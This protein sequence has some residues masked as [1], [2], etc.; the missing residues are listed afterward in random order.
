MKIEHL[1]QAAGIVSKLGGR[2]PASAVTEV[3]L[4]KG[5]TMPMVL[6]P[7]TAVTFTK[8]IESGGAPWALRAISCFTLAARGYIR[9]QIQLPNGRFLFGRNGIDV[10][11]FCG[12]GSSRWA[13]DP[14]LICEPGSKIQVK[15]SDDLHLLTETASVMMTFEGACLYYVR[16]GKPVKDGAD[17]A[18][19]PRYF[20]DENQNILA[21]AW[22]SNEGLETPAGFVDEYYVHASAA[23]ETNPAAGTWT[24][25]AAAV[26]GFPNPPLFEIQIAPGYDFYVRRMLFD[27]RVT[28]SATAKVFGKIRTGEGFTLNENYIDLG[29]CLCGA[30][31]PGLWRVKGGDSV[32]TDARLMDSMG[33]GTVTMRV[34]LEGFRRRA[35]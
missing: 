15:L 11:M 33:T 20:L 23:L 9:V 3:A 14:E 19:S 18:A 35:A 13:H 8:E 32:Y 30:E 16:A 17:V 27:I 34:F 2:R 24:V 1:Q 6:Q 5:F 7:G 25:A 21:P 29:F 31:Y 4:F 12:I 28:G 10:A 22:W 26:T